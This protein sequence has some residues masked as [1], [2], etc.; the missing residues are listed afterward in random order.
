MNPIPKVAAKIIEGTANFISFTTPD[1][2][3][4]VED[5]VK[6]I[7]KKEDSAGRVRKK[8]NACFQFGSGE[9]IYPKEMFITKA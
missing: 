1:K 4:Y 6:P 2:E 7:A 5:P 3:V 8:T 9:K